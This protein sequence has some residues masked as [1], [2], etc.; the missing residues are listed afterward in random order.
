MPGAAA[1]SPAKESR[2]GEPGAG[3]RLDRASVTS[4]GPRSGAAPCRLLARQGARRG[5]AQGS[6]RQRLSSRGP[7]GRP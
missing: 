2:E 1:A 3:W 6:D 5:G 4:S 7:A